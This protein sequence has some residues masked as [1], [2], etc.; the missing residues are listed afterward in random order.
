MQQYTQLM[1]VLMGLKHVILLVEEG[2]EIGVIKSGTA[3]RCTEGHVCV[4]VSG[5]AIFYLWQA[6]MSTLTWLTPPSV[7]RLPSPFP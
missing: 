2:H 6:T 3:K 5:Q 1:M 7:C 4:P